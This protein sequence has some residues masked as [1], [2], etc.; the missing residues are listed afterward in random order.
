MTDAPNAI[1]RTSCRDRRRS[2]TGRTSISSATP[3]RVS[4]GRIVPKASVN[5]IRAGYPFNLTSAP[6]VCSFYVDTRILP[7]ANPL[8]LRDELR[9]CSPGRRRGTVELFL[10]RPGFEAVG[11]ERLIETIRRCHDQVFPTAADDRRGPRHL[12]VARHERVQRAGDPGDLLRAALGQPR[13]QESFKVEDLPTRRSYMPGSRWTSATRNGRRTPLGAHLNRAI[14]EYVAARKLAPDQDAA[15]RDAS[16]ADGDRHSTDRTGGPL[17]S[18]TGSRLTRDGNSGQIK[19]AYRRL[20]RQTTPTQTPSEPDA[21]HEFKRV[22]RAYEILG[23]AQ[24]RRTT[25]RAVP[26]PVW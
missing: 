5:A 6:Q 15:G 11:A 8:D 2:S 17:R 16:A 26:R 24:R 3:T 7:G 14:A 13:G 12:H 19:A 23:N 18:A 1:V 9:A 20:A 22:A 4:T 10:Y 25:K 21:E